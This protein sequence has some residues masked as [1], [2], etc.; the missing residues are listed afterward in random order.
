MYLSTS[1][2]NLEP[3]QRNVHLQCFELESGHLRQNIRKFMDLSDLSPRLVQLRESPDELC[4]DEA[5]RE[6][7]A[8]SAV[9]ESTRVQCKM[10][11]AR[12][13]KQ[14]TFAEFTPRAIEQFRQKL[15]KNRAKTFDPALGKPMQWLYGVVRS[16]VGD[17]TRSFVSELPKGVQALVAEPEATNPKAMIEHLELLEEVRNFLN[18]QPEWLIL[19]G[20]VLLKEITVEEAAEIAS[21]HPSTIRR[22]MLELIRRLTEHF[23]PKDRM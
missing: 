17:A 16:A 22:W 2:P 6:I 14:V 23:R 15:E 3:V 10:A 1:R 13:N 21:V 19:A 9:M 12:F 8:Q 7:F 20:K 18:N 4:A 11:V 5:I